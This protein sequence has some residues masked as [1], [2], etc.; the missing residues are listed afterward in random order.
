MKSSP[1]H[2]GFATLIVLMLLAI[3]STYVIANGVILQH[4]RQ[5]IKRIEQRQINPDREAP[6]HASQP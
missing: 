1:N 3:I 6:C 4:L 5:Q 2:R